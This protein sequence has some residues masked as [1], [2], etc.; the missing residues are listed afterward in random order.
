MKISIL[1]TP[2]LI[3]DETLSSW[4]VRSA[5]YQGC[6]PMVLSWRIWDKYRIWTIDF[7]RN[8]PYEHL[9]ALSKATGLGID[10]L[11]EMLLIHQAK[12][13]VHDFNTESATWSVS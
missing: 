10:V 5:L 9:F 6:D 3:V 2:H 1:R 4:L 8:L 11:N 7:E 12:K 13:C